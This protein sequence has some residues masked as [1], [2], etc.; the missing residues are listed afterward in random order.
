[1]QPTIMYCFYIYFDLNERTQRCEICS[2]ETKIALSFQT[3]ESLVIQNLSLVIAADKAGNFLN[4]HA[5]IKANKA[6]I[7]AL[8]L[9]WLTVCFC[10]R[11]RAHFGGVSIERRRVNL[12]ICL[13]Y[14]IYLTQ[15]L[16][17]GS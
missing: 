7:N 8:K 5:K 15:K 13:G 12:N 10:T 11:N 16:S 4:T 9:V 3:P 14:S 2:L 17:E 1:M 6:A